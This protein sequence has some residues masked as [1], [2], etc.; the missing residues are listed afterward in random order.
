[1]KKLNLSRLI[2]TAISTY[3]IVFHIVS[4]ASAGT[5]L[6]SGHLPELP[7]D[8]GF[9]GM[10]AGTSQ[11]VLIAAGGTNFVKIDPTA[12]PVKQWY[13]GIYVLPSADDAWIESEQRL[14]KQ[15]ANGASVT[16]DDAL[17]CIGGDDA[18][19]CYANVYVL[20]WRNDKIEISELPPMPSP[21]AHHAAAIVDDILYVA[22]G[23]EQPIATTSTNTF[24]AL[25]LSVTHA[26]RRWG[27]LEPW[28]G[29]ARH[30]AVAGSIDGAFYL[31]GGVGQTADNDG[32]P[33]WQEP[34]LHDAYR[35]DPAAQNDGEHAAWTKLP[36]LPRSA[37]GAASP[38]PAMG[39]SHLLIIGGVTEADQHSD[40]TS[41]NGFTRERL[42][43]HLPSTQ[44]TSLTPIPQGESRVV[45][46]AVEW[47]EQWVLV[48]GEVASKIRTPMVTTLN[49]S[50]TFGWLNWL[51]LGAYLIAMLGMGL[52]FSRRGNTTHDFFLAGQ[53]IPW[54]AAGLSVYGTLLSGISFMAIPAETYTSDWA[55]VI[56]TILLI[57][58]MPLIIYCYLPFFRR[59]HVVTA[60]EYL[61]KRFNLP[62]RLFA[63]CSFILF[64][65]SRMGIVLFIPAIALAATTGI[66]IYLCILVMGIICVI[67]TAMGGMEAVIWTDVLQVL[68]LI[69]GAVLCLIIVILNVDGGIPEVI[70]TANNADKFRVFDWGWSSERSVVWVMLVGFFFL[71]LAPFTSDQSVVQRYLTTSDEKQAGRSLWLN[72]WMV[73]PTIPI[74]FGLGTALY[75]F[76]TRNPSVIAP[77]ISSEVV[78]WFI[79]HQLPAGVA[80]LIIAAIFAATMS[81]MDSALNSISTVCVNDI[82]QRF[83]PQTQDHTAVLTAKSLTIVF[84]VFGTGTA[85]LLAASDIQSLFELF[86]AFLGVLCGSLAGVF[87][88]A[89]F[90]RRTNATGALLGAI[91]GSALPLIAQA[92]SNTSPYLFGA[93]GVVATV[94]TGYLF[95]LILPGKANGHLSIPGGMLKANPVADRLV[96]NQPVTNRLDS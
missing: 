84:G 27:I 44:W 20:R 61:E 25:D 26:E 35:Y 71:N 66:D 47:N 78:P 6:V 77:Q 80:G 56:G 17:I 32:N 49:V 1:M 29:P 24:W 85:V 54:W 2:V 83:R 67:Y 4:S 34:Y 38:A 87:V 76:Y 58:M 7:N 10:F 79:V 45:L 28:P 19:E 65:V 81:S 92:I 16:Y 72:A 13:D 69:G 68:V 57:P 53:R 63:S 55:I 37:I 73:L 70:K 94:I 31:I 91:V 41:Y 62:I 23:I 42:A 15:L 64:Q 75:V 60:Y 48:G 12:S 18:R 52:Y 51:T 3:M 36:D 11:G 22:G 40:Q 5:D 74:F 95:S 21:R 30:L 43:F 90:S 46:P 82:Q 39:S 86:Q 50:T 8:T 59:L 89:I 33:T 96:T 14:P 9:A 88:L 93:I